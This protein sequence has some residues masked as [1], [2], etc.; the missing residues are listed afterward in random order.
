MND[1]Q[2]SPLD[3]GEP[4][5]PPPIILR[6]LGDRAEGVIERYSRGPN[7]FDPNHDTPIAI[8]R[9]PDGSLGSIWINTVVAQSKFA[10]ERPKVGERIVFTFLGFREGANAT[11]RDFRL[12]LPDREDFEP[13][14]GAL[15]DEVF[16]P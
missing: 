5:Y 15:V 10:K 2:T 6:E 8:V 11:Y 7:R 16:P 12:E 14:W 3:N 4:E 1:P 9:R 13:D